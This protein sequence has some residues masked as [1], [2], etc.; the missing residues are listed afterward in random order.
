MVGLRGMRHIGRQPPW[1]VAV[2]TRIEGTLCPPLRIRQRA[3]RCCFAV[4]IKAFLPVEIHTLLRRGNPVRVVTTDAAERSLAGLCTPTGDNLF[5]LTHGARRSLPGRPFID[6]HQ[7][8]VGH[9]VTGSKIVLPTTRLQDPLATVEMTLVTD[10][11]S[12]RRTQ[13]TRIDNRLGSRTLLTMLGNVLGTRTMTTFA[14]QSGFYEWRRGEEFSASRFRFGPTNVAV[15]A[16]L[17][18]PSF[19]PL[20]LTRMIARR[21][22][23]ALSVGIPGQRR[24]IHR[25]PLIADKTDP[26]LSRSN[27]VIHRHTLIVQSGPVRGA[28]HFT[29]VKS[30][31]SNGTL[32]APSPRRKHRFRHDVFG[33]FVHRASGMG[34]GMPVVALADGTMAFA[35]T[36]AAS[37]L[38]GTALIFRPRRWCD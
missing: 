12:R 32:V 3:A 33:H 26:P 18:D 15:Q 20:V 34:H 8:D 6:E 9:E 22:V 13:T 28:A 30:P 36:F 16:A 7:P 21:K 17:P 23:P 11:L 35:T 1:H 14:T 19:K 5:R 29:M 38:V 27:G 31:L 4:T 24:L 10:T 25:P 37:E 2:D